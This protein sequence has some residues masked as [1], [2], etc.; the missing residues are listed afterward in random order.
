MLP[1]LAQYYTH[2]TAHQTEFLSANDAILAINL[3]EKVKNSGVLKQP[4]HLKSRNTDDMK[5]DILSGFPLI[6]IKSSSG[7]LIGCTTVSPHANTDT[8][9]IRSFCID[10]AFVGQGLAKKLAET[11]IEWAAQND[12]QTIVA[13]VALDNT[14]S[15]TI[16]EK[17]G[18]AP[19][20]TDIDKDDGYAY[21]IMGKG[22]IKEIEPTHPTPEFFPPA[23][24]LNLAVA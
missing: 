19:T 9:M 18:F 22:L 15:L 17:Q 11:A 24:H 13:K 12:K 8:V 7:D 21:H 6:G 3:I 20:H 14:D 10:P 23:S 4:Y 1:A 2:A 5:Q 16:F